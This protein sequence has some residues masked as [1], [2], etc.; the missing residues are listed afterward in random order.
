MTTRKHS[1]EQSETPQLAAIW[2]SLE[3]ANP[4]LPEDKFQKLFE[5]EV[6]EIILTAENQTLIAE[7]AEEIAKDLKTPD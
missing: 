3:K 6:I 1:K 7:M 5:Q 4:G 2:D